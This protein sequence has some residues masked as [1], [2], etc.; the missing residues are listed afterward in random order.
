VA[1]AFLI[2]C[3]VAL[4]AGCELLFVYASDLPEISRALRKTSPDVSPKVYG[5]CDGSLAGKAFALQRRILMSTSSAPKSCTAPVTSI[6]EPAFE[7][8]LGD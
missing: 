4:G 6:E 1:L 8:A 2:L 7:G 5:R 3:A